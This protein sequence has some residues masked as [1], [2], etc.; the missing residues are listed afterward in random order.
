MTTGADHRQ[1]REGGRFGLWMLLSLLLILSAGWAAVVL[2]SGRAITAP[3]WVTAKIEERA[4]D[5]LGGPGRLQLGEIV[6]LMGEGYVPRV[7]MRNLRL[8]DETG[9]EIARVPELRARL[10]LETLFE[11]QLGLSRLTMVGSE[12]VLRR[13]RFGRF[14][15]AFGTDRSAPTGGTIPEI[16]AAI[17]TA[18]ARPALSG[19]TQV[20]GEALR[21]TFQ[22]ALTG[23]VWRAEGGL[24]SLTQEEQSR[25][26]T[27]SFSLAGG[28]GARPAAVRI[29]L[30]AP[31]GEGPLD[32]K[33]DFSNVTAADLAAQL[34]ALAFLTAADAPLSANIEATLDATGALAAFEGSLEMGAGAI[35]P[36]GAARPIPFDGAKATLS[37][38]PASG[39]IA[40]SEVSASTPEARFEASGQAL[41]GEV[42]SASGLPG[43]LIGQLALKNIEFDPAGELA[44]PA[45]FDRGAIDMRLTIKPFRIEIGQ[46]A[47][48][49]GDR[50]FLASG[51]FAAD[52]DG[53]RAAMDLHLDQIE[54]DRLA[55]LWPLRVA[56]KVREW[57]VKN[58]TEGLLTDVTSA[59]RIR[60][61]EEARVALGYEFSDGTVRFLPTLPP[62][63]GGTGHAT[64]DDYRYTMVL[65][66]GHVDSPSGERV[67][68][69][70]SVLTVPDIR[71]DP[72]PAEI[73]LETDSTI[74]AALTLLDEPP[75]GF[76]TKAGRPTDLAEGHARMSAVI[77]LPLAKNVPADQIN[78]AVSGKLTDVRADRLLP[79]RVL[80]ADELT[81]T[82]TNAG[83][84]IG[85]PAR[86]G[87][88][89]IDA[90]WS[91]PL[92]TEADGTSRVEGTVALNQDF[93]DEFA[94]ALPSG[95]LTREGTGVLNI[96]LPKEGVAGFSLTSDLTGMGLSLPALGWSKGRNTGGSLEVAGS[97]G[98]PVSIDRIALSA[99]G[100][101]ASGRIDLADDGSF[102]SATFDRVRAGRWLDAPVRLT[103]R[104]AGRAPAVTVTGGTFDLRNTQI[105]GR[106][107]G[108]G[109][110]LTLALDRVIV[111][112]GIVFRNFRAD[113]TTQGGLNGRF[114]AS[115]AGAAP[116]SGV[117]APSQGGTAVRL[118]SADA[119]AVLRA[120]GLL[121]S[122]RQGNMDLTLTPLPG[123]GR[124]DGRL[125]ITGLRIRG[126]PALADLLGAI[127]VVGLLEQLNG[128]GLV[129]NEVT[130]EFTLEPRG[131]TLRRGSG[132][133]ASLGVSMAGIYDLR[134]KVMDMRG[135]ISPIYLL[136]GIGQIFT[137][138][139]EGLF[140]FNYRMSGPASDPRIRVNPLSILT[141]GMF[142]EI[143][144][145]PPPRL[146]Q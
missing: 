6:A 9:A 139:G 116:V 25:T 21:L 85:G 100:L 143:F 63:A 73:R 41:L 75:F 87:A 48:V 112:E 19:L 115:L 97:L 76:L 86:I 28:A 128:Q 33:A 117:L 103:S 53:W 121:D 71:I 17:E 64:I 16:L 127:S 66:A 98:D 67:E 14:D 12:M 107:A 43:Q 129:F 52:P 74:T 11:G 1:R 83:L 15:L 57:L 2:Y 114:T 90:S 126:A 56:P 102:A 120:S 32:V 106:G 110:P 29:A 44:E 4:A 78:F 18:F 82:A 70:G 35:R 23:R 95:T 5:A 99:P 61:G 142:R 146:S 109:G 88:A 50:H 31:R 141:P 8:R 140:G 69:K 68:A 22:D 39:R 30:T 26:L 81:L 118:Q 122:A 131:V 135:V 111:S 96:T 54:H 80:E 94:I 45:R 3:H 60:P 119:G 108:G 72:A 84:T 10:S 13:D 144:R 59:I 113:L 40:F 91:L 92:G 65:T 34:P 42:D 27:M 7:V 49:G 47:L 123:E 37:F 137:R 51:D 36:V 133:G 124:Y 38:D 20:S 79:G 46:L 58:V 77:R 125:R 104:G 55:A 134:T 145:A 89:R 24:V 130:G 132:V 101:D 138:R 136:N 93:L 62:I 105:A